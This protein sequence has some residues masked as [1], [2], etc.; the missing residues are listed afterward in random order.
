MQGFLTLL[1]IVL[2]MIYVVSPYDFIPDLFPITGWIDDTA[3][4]A[5]AFYYLRNGKFPDFLTRFFRSLTGQP[6]PSGNT[7]SGGYRP[8]D[9]GP[10]AGKSDPHTVL[11]VKPG[12]S[13]EEIHA[14]YRRLVHQYHPDKVAHLGAEFQEIARKKFVEIQHA[15]ESLTGGPP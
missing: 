6:A 5:L 14:A 2:A 7:A 11:G 13:K 1:I 4:L 10:S 3:I 15:Y 9:T 12:A 8:S